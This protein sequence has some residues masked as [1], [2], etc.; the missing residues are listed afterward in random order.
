MGPRSGGDPQSG[1]G[2]SLT[3]TNVKNPAAGTPVRVPAAGFSDQDAYAAQMEQ[4]VSPASSASSVV[5]VSSP[6]WGAALISGQP[7]R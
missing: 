6:P 3:L 4:G 5:I 7:A 1:L 2:I